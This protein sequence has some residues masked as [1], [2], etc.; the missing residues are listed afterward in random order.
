MWQ[1]VGHDWVV[2][3]LNNSIARQR[4]FH[5]YLFAG[6]SHVGKRTLAVNLA[7][8]LNCEDQ[9]VP[10]G[11]CVPC[12]KIRDGVHPDVR[13]VDGRYQARVLEEPLAQQRVLRIDTIRAMEREVSLKPFEG[14]R[15]VFI[16]CDAETMTTE[17]ANCLLKTLEEPPPHVV[18]VLTALDKRLLLPTIVSRCQVFGLRPVSTELIER[19][20]QTECGLDE[21]RARIL[22][23]LSGGRIGWAITAARDG[24]VLQKREETL[25]QLL[26]LPKMTRVDRLDYAERLSRQP[27]SM[28]EVMELWLGW[29]RDLLLVKIGRTEMVANVDLR[30]ALEEQARRHD[31]KE[32]YGFI[33]SVRHTARQL[34]YNANPRLALEVLVLD[35][36]VSKN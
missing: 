6:P 4:V 27:R 13:M 7:Q 30:T 9:D 8:A 14:R 32:I 15:K 2:A 20:L 29:W 18:L 5:A 3:L 26:A 11:R 21:E 16:I 36:P 31:L 28:W 17:A 22:A 1:V 24:A 19:R 10:C 23:R 25:K 35:L 12:S 34:E 33:G